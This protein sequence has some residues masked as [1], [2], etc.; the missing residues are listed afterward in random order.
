MANYHP[1]L[2]KLSNS[3]KE[4][5][6]NENNEE[7]LKKFSLSNSADYLKKFSWAE[8]LCIE[9]E[10]KYDDETIKQIRMKCSCNLET[11]KLKKLQEAY[12]SSNNT[13]D[14]VIKVNNQEQGFKLLYENNELFLIYPTCYCPFVKRVD[15][16]ISK[17]WCY[18]TLGYTKNA[19][20]YIFEKQ[21]LIE[22]IESVKT[23]SN[24]CKIKIICKED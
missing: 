21:V 23:G 16:T 15:K 12:Q 17:T 4:I 19:F 9:L 6:P 3:I 2:L 8:K 7:F 14:F 10:N 24:R 22:L 1:H 13:T 11:S 5:N 20:E 18:C